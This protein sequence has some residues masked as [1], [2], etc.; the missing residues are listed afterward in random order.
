MPYLIDFPMF[1]TAVL[2]FIIVS[3]IDTIR[4]ELHPWTSSSGEVR[5]YVNDWFDLIGDVLES[6]VQNEWNAPPMEKIKRA[7]VWFDL[8]AHVHVDGLK[9]ELTV[10]IIRNNLEDRFFQR[11]F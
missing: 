5:Y 7:K 8:S 3:S 11:E 10:E 9:D 4:K 6:F 2:R 1:Y